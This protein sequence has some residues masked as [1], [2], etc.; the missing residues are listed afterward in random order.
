MGT[1]NRTDDTE[2]MEGDLACEA[3]LEVNGPNSGTGGGGAIWR[4]SLMTD[5]GLVSGGDGGTS[6][7]AHSD[8]ARRTSS[9]A[10]ATLANVSGKRTSNYLDT[11]KEEEE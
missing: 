9:G 1:K 7:L 6:R 3:A 4:G 2:L 5:E 10:A 11:W 8:R